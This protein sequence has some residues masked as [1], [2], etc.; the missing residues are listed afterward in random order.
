MKRSLRQQLQLVLIVF[1]LLMSPFLIGLHTSVYAASTGGSNSNTNTNSDPHGGSTGG[2]NSNNNQNNNNQNNN[3]QG[4]NQTNQNNQASQTDQGNQTANNPSSNNNGLSSNCP[5]GGDADPTGSGNQGCLKCI[6][7]NITDA[8][9]D[10]LKKYKQDHPN[11]VQCGDSA[12]D[13]SANCDQNGCDLV[14]KYV[15]PTINVL[16][17][18]VGLVAVISIVAGAIQY[19]TSTGDPQKTSAAKSRI[20]KTIFAL[21][22][23]AFLYAF[24]EF[25][26]PGGVF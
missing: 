16:S 21:V 17:V 14:K 12:A 25:I 2:S 26:I 18:I 11:A 5:P 13:P 6:P 24:L 4:N 9:G 3:N 15:N 20:S 10:T 22:A 7:A 19:I 1:S 23:Y 8:G